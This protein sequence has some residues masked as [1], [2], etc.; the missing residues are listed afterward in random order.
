[1]PEFILVRGETI[2]I[3]FTGY[4]RPMDALGRITLPKKVRDELGMK[5]GDE[6]LFAVSDD[7]IELSK[8][9][10]RCCLC[11]EELKEGEIKRVKGKAVCLKCVQE[12]KRMVKS[13]HFSF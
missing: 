4:V 1:M 12:I 9:V 5:V 11:R 7:C 2:K 13:N 3:K 10:P 8:N 6:L